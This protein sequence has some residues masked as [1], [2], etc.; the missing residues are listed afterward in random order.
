M[1][2]AVKYAM[3]PVSILALTVLSAFIW[4]P[5]LNARMHI[6]VLS[7]RSIPESGGKRIFYYSTFDDPISTN[8]IHEITDDAIPRIT[9]QTGIKPFEFVHHADEIPIDDRFSRVW[10]LEKGYIRLTLGFWT[11]SYTLELSTGAGDFL[12][13]NKGTVHVSSQEK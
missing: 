1:K 9:E 7:S 2:T 10:Q 12:K 5:P 8:M 3:H 6:W 13:Q 4:C 11:D